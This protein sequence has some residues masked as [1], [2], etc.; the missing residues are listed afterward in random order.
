MKLCISSGIAE[1][2]GD[3][4]AAAAPD[5]ELILL[6]PDGSLEGGTLEEIEVFFNSG[7]LLTREGELEEV[8]TA[9]SRRPCAGSRAARPDSSTRC[10]RRSAAATGCA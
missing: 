3:R 6:Q 2:Y 10:W 1:R 7:D 8:I 9:I 4:I 5:A